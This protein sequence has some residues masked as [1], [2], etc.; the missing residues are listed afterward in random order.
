[1]RFP[2]QIE[3]NP[4]IDVSYITF[5]SEMEIASNERL[6]VRDKEI[7]EEVILHELTLNL[8]SSPPQQEEWVQKSPPP[9]YELE[10]PFP[11][12]LRETRKVEYN[13]YIYETFR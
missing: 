8:K 9:P 3:L 2:S 12:A 5:R 11:E 13:K 7:E 1:M 6:V 4:K 10:P